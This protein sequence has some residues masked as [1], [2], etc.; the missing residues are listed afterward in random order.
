METSSVSLKSTQYS[1]SLQVEPNAKQEQAKVP[2]SNARPAADADTVKLSAE[3]QRLAQKSQAASNVA[4]P[5]INDGNQ[6]RQTANVVA[7]RLRQQ[8]AEAS[9]SMSAGNGQKLKSLLN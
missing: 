1:K 7:E 3:S 2:V 9:S 6:A 8:P 5:T 4:V